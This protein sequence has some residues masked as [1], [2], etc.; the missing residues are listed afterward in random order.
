MLFIAEETF[1]QAIFT[2]V[3]NVLKALRKVAVDTKH[4]SRLFFPKREP[5]E[6]LESLVSSTSLITVKDSVIRF[7]G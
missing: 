1:L 2:V 3:E 6:L 5:K 4:A 7:P